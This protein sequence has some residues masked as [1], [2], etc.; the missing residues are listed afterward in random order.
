MNIRFEV[1]TQVP[2][3]FFRQSLTRNF[4]YHSLQTDIGLAQTT[5]F[6]ADLQETIRRLDAMLPFDARLIERLARQ[7]CELRCE[8]VVCDIAPMGIAVAESASL[9]SIL[10]EN[11][12]WDW[13]YEEYASADPRIM[14]HADYLRAVFDTA[15]YH[16]QTEPVSVHSAGAT[17][18]APPVS[19]EPVTPA[20]LVRE[21]LGIPLEASTV[22]ITMG[23]I[24][25]TD[26]PFIERLEQAGE[27]FFVIPGG[28]QTH[29]TRNNLI[30]LPHNSGFYHPDL[31]N[32][33]DAVIGKIGYSTVAEAFHARVP[34]YYVMR[35]GFRE[36]PVLAKFV[37]EQ[38]QGQAMPEED[39][40]RGRWLHLLDEML[41][42]PRG[43]GRHRPNGAHDIAD[44]LLKL[45]KA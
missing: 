9:P 4:G 21:K 27:I 11:F 40:V 31:V 26:Y 25:A 39:F 24:A 36:S 32:A 3:W 18:T 38:M 41:Q 33:S 42:R 12:T 45:L 5:P 17:L 20:S 2:E 15:Q 28:S 8:L 6:A 19:R 1:F 30:L 29:E 34:F 44:F 37:D 13:I 14:H 22:L 7:M 43:E 35:G 23:G 16:I 10:V